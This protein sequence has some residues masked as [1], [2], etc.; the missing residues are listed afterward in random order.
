ME[1]SSKLGS[2]FKRKLFDGGLDL[3]DAHRLNDIQK[4]LSQQ[5]ENVTTEAGD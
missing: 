5:R 3:V 1:P 2:L 4:H